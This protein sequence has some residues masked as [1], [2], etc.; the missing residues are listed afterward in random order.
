MLLPSITFCDGVAS[1]TDRGVAAMLDVAAPAPAAGRDAVEAP[2]VDEA[3]A[4]T[5][6][7]TADGSTRADKNE[8]YSLQYDARASRE[9]SSNTRASVHTKSTAF[10]TLEPRPTSR[11][12]SSNRTM[13]RTRSVA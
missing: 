9:Q 12:S 8:G 3:A 1:C 5:V 4:S 10:A 7:A 13:M 2:P 6:T 11:V